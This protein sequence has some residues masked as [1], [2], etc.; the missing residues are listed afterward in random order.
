M[1]KDIIMQHL[2]DLQGI[3]MGEQM[4]MV[5]IIDRN[6]DTAHK[7]KNLKHELDLEIKSISQSIEYLKKQNP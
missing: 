6:T 1:M 4:Q 7:A 2:H 5:R 3:R